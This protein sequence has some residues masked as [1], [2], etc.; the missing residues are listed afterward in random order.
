M[1]SN[2]TSLYI[3][4][5]FLESARREMCQNHMNDYLECVKDKNNKFENCYHLHIEKFENCMKTL[6]IIKEMNKNDS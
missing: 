6:K 2:T 3:T 5:Q 1:V 4:L